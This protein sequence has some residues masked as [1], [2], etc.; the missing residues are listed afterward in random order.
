MVHSK[1]SD[2]L[3]GDVAWA[4]SSEIRQ[5]NHGSFGGVPEYVAKI[6]NNLRS[7]MLADPVT[8]FAGLPSRVA[9][10]RVKISRILGVDEEDLVFVAN[11]SAG[12]SA[13]FDSFLGKEPVNV[14]VTNHG[15]GAVSMGARRLAELTGGSFNVVSIPISFK[16]AEIQESVL[17]AC[18]QYSPTILVI[19]QITSATAEYFPAEEICVEARKRGIFTLVDGAHAPGILA[20]PVCREADYW[21]GNFHK[22]ACAP[23]GCAVLVARAGKE[24]LY[25]VIDSW[26]TDLSFPQRFD[27]TGTMDVT[28]W[29][30][31]P[32]AWDYISREIGW[33]EIYRYS[34]NIADYGESRLREVLD[35]EGRFE[36]VGSPVSC[37]RILPLP[38]PLGRTRIEA[39]S[40]RIPFIEKVQIALSF[41]SFD[42]VG[43]LRFSTHAYTCKD[44]F[45]HLVS[46]GIPVLQQ[47]AQAVHDN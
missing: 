19:D 37:M 41:T 8:W 32:I 3:A 11:A 12:A 15:Y 45:D 39:D 10:A 30:V 7:Q 20:N 33:S 18:D 44:D 1:R 22:F 2:S 28:S 13:V 42:G 24:R 31:A 17:T 9:N 36:G 21:I 23:P 5:L 35:P 40:L 34:K 47:W 4:L 16:Q 29:L 25:P 14:L 43:Y 46:A 6:Q 26:G 27:H 38:E